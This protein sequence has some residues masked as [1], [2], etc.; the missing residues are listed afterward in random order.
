[1]INQK[2]VSE[3]RPLLIGAGLGS[4]LGSGVIVALAT[5]ISIWQNYLSLS[6]AQVGIIS[7]VLTLSIA[8]GSL[9][10]GKIAKQIGLVRAFNLLNLF[11]VVGGL[12]IVCTINF[13]MLVIGAL[14]SGFVTG[15]DLPISLTVISKDVAD[16]KI[17]AEL[18]SSTQVYWTIGILLAAI[19]SFVTSK[20]PGELSARL[21]MGLIVLVGILTLLIRNSSKK[22]QSIHRSAPDPINSE[23]VA[24]KGSVLKLLFGKDKKYLKF[25]ICI[26]VFYC[27]WN[28]LANTFGQF[29][30]FMLVKANATQ[31]FATGAGLLLTIVV[32]AIAV[33]FAKIAGGK[34]RNVVFVIGIGIIIFALVA[35]AFSSNN[36]FLIVAFLAL[37]NVGSTFAGEAMY[38]VW[39]QES[40]P[41]SYRSSIQGFINGF[42][43]LCCAAFALITPLLVLPE[44]IKTTMLGFA[45]LLFVAGVFGVIQIRLQ[46]KYNVGSN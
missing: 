24:K 10:A 14:I 30:T 27:G 31:S 18:V 13:P 28:L 5:T 6:M 25:F 33:I 34:N 36:L 4:V 21:V 37:Q 1:M 19:T 7:S 40:F 3:F 20:L 29:Q 44:N 16:E 9:S 11:F 23:L 2:K 39:T 38:K 22:L 8:I 45:V 17:R 15:A 26:L 41:M 35:L 42:S 12:L 46:K 43:R 32:L